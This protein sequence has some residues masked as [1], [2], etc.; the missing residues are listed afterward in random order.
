MKSNGRDQFFYTCVV[1][2]KQIEMILQAL[3]YEKGQGIQLDEFFSAAD[4][5]K[6]D[7]G[8][9]WAQ[10]VISRRVKPSS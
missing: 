5:L 3:E 8:K 2:G 4:G 9:S 1:L 10:E 7:V 6:T